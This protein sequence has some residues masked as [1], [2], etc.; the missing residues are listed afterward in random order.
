M[1]ILQI[2]TLCTAI[3]GAALGI[4]NTWHRFSKERVRLRVV[5]KLGWRVGRT[6]ILAAD[7]PAAAAE[8][9]TGGRPHDRLCIEVINLSAFPVTVCDVGFGRVD[10]SRFAAVRPELSHGK[11]WPVRLEARESFVAYLLPN[12]KLSEGALKWARAYAS[13]DCGTS[14]YGSSPI[15]REYCRSLLAK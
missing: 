8:D 13:T 4:M 14:S 6:G 5:P 15:F 9:P 7:R 3:I 2:A 1:T 11:A 10:R 12:A